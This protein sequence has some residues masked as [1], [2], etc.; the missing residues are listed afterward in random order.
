MMQG[1]AVAVR[2]GATRADFEATPQTVVV[3]R[4]DGWTTCFRAYRWMEEGKIHHRY[5]IDTLFIHI[6]IYIH[7]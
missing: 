7:T 5:C 2:M 1:F 3:E 6:Y 4:F